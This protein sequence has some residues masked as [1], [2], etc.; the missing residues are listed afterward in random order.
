MGILIVLL[1][2]I[3]LGVGGFIVQQLMTSD[4]LPDDITF[5]SYLRFNAVLLCCGPIGWIAMFVCT[6]AYIIALSGEQEIGKKI[7][8]WVV[9]EKSE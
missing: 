7:M 1:L 3:W 4:D 5:R 9:G 8:K 6:V 2:V